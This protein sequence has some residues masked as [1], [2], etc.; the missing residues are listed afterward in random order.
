MVDFFAS[1][2]NQQ[3]SN[4]VKT[5]VNENN[6]GLKMLNF[7]Y[8]GHK[9]GNPEKHPYSGNQK[10]KA[11]DQLQRGFC[12]I[13]HRQSFWPLATGFWPVSRAGLNPASIFERRPLYFASA[14][15]RPIFVKNAPFEHN[16]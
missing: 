3:N 10:Q 9:L 11:P 13:F 7:L 1:P 2:Y 5:K 6:I 12:F 16:R 4:Q 14:Q 8:F 15:R